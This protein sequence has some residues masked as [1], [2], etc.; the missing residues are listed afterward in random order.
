MRART[1]VMDVPEVDQQSTVTGG[2]SVG[3]GGGEDSWGLWG[4]VDATDWQREEQK[5]QIFPS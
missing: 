3:A 1:A 4:D 5:E 2:R